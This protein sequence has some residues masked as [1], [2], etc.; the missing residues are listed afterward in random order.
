MASLKEKNIGG[1]GNDVYYRYKRPELR[2]KVE[3][4]RSN[5]VKTVIENI[6]AIAKALKVPPEYPTRF[7]GYEMCS[8]ASFVDSSDRTC[9]IVKGNH[10][11]KDLDK[12]LDE[13]IKLFVLCPTCKLPETKIS[14]KKKEVRIKCASC[15]HAGPIP[16]THRLVNFIAKNPPSSF[17]KTEAEAP[18]L[19]KKGKAKTKPSPVKSVSTD[20]SADSSADSSPRSSTDSSP[21][22][23]QHSKEEEDKTTETDESWSLDTSVEA[24]KKRRAEFLA[25]QLSDKSKDTKKG[26]REK[27]DI[28]S[29]KPESV[30]KTYVDTGDRSVIDI[31]SELARLQLKHGLSSEE[32]LRVLL[33]AVIDLSSPRTLGAQFAK[34]ADL[35]KRVAKDKS[36]S[37]LLI[38]SIERL[39]DSGSIHPPSS[40]RTPL[41]KEEGRGKAQEDAKSNLIIRIPVVLQKLYEG[42]V[43]TEESILSWAQS[44]PEASAWAVGRDSALLA[45]K[46]AK[47]LVE[48]LESAEEDEE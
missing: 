4:P 46:S 48:W 2:T 45:R 21:T 31:S 26:S 25:A 38:A 32:R 3:K 22:E 5:G 47:P 19:T 29:S 16:T 36:S 37:T 7:L 10:T 43:L 42:D 9:T 1:A 27:E 30:L 8:Q 39:L 13:F 24:Q 18:D 12:A 20:S 33:Q 34:H 40:D 6:S 23:E 11:D 35:L 44:P 17:A 28:D 15:G 41:E 14:V